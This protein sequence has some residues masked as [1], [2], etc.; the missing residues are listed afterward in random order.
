ML[1]KRRSCL[2]WQDCGD[3]FQSGLPRPGSSGHGSTSSGTAL[4]RP[5]ATSQAPIA[6]R[7]RQPPEPGPAEPAG[8]AQG[9]WMQWEGQVVLGK[10]VERRGHDIFLARNRKR[11]VTP[12]IGV[13][14][15]LN[16][17]HRSSL[18]VSCAPIAL[19]AILYYHGWKL[20]FD[21]ACSFLSRSLS[22]EC[23]PSLMIALWLSAPAAGSGR[24]RLSAAH[25]ADLQRALLFVPWR[26][27]AKR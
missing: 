18:A 14:V 7:A 5:R 26:P 3:E 16:R 22:D 19:V 4:P 13:I 24:G 6:K 27:Q 2:R 10:N 15:I 1:D 12:P 21:P 8:I 9:A 20:A 25:Q 17:R 23:L 11:A